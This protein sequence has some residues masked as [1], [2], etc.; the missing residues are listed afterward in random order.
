MIKHYPITK[1]DKVAKLYSDK[2]GVPVKY[3]C[4]TEFLYPDQPADIF[5]RNTPHPEFGNKYFGIRFVGNEAYIFDADGIEKFK[6]G[7]VENDNGDLEYSQFRHECKSFKNGNMIDGGRSYI[8]SSGN[9][10]VYNIVNG[11]L[12]ANDSRAS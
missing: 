6:F 3:V 8:R 7:M 9:F 4:T 1:T 5:Y 12:V 10:I 11:E 2:D